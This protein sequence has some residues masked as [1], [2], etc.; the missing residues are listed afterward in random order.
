MATLPISRSL[1]SVK[2]LRPFN[3]RRDLKEAADLIELCFD[4]TLTVD[5]RRYLRHMRTVAKRNASRW[6]TIAAS[7]GG[8]PLAG[9]VWE[10]EGR[11]VGNLSLLP[12]FHRGRRIYLIANVA[13]HPDYRRRGIARALTQAALEKAGRWRVQ[14]IWL[15]V[16]DDNPP[17][18]K[19][20]TS[21]G[22]KPQV[23]RA[24]WDVSPRSIL[25]EPP[26]ET[27]VTIR[28][29]RHWDKQR[30]WLLKN[31]PEVLHWHMPLSMQAFKPGLLGFLFRFF[32][33]KRLRHWAA[34][35]RE[36]LLGVLTWQETER[37]SDYLWL[38]APPETEALALGTILPF[39][40][41]EAR[42]RRP[43][44]LN[45]PAGRAVDFLQA[46]GFEHRHTLIWMKV[47]P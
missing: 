21:M 41:R 20:Y 22:F 24:T 32:G 7:S 19:L 38:A 33:E 31:Y 47:K 10:D 42:L 8:L 11:L 17:A 15:H 36:G 13:V 12:F 25:G 26:P 44:S 2:H 46:A 30:A 6:V 18:I 3:V 39:L 37:Y 34:R 35:H 14:N 4:E 1:S 45:Y 28:A 5:G 16:R 27:R 23:R 43:L 9:F 40:R 29:G